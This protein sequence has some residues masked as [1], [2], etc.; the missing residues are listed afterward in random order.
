MSSRQN[1]FAW[2]SARI[3]KPFT[4]M[5]AA[6]QPPSSAAI[7]PR[8]TRNTATSPANGA[9]CDQP[10]APEELAQLIH[11]RPPML[12]VEVEVSAE[13]QVRD[14]R[15]RARGDLGLLERER[16]ELAEPAY[17]PE[18][19]DEERRHDRGS[20]REPL[21]PTARDDVGE[22][23]TR[24]HEEVRRLEGTGGADHQAGHDRIQD[25]AGREGADDEEHPRQDEHHRREVGHRGQA[26]RLWEELLAPTLLIAIDEER[27]RR[28]R[29]DHPQEGRPVRE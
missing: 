18:E 13:V 10:R 27:D 3:E 16:G 23:D 25:T 11:L 28:E 17:L 4:R 2:M 1:V 12:E 21:A 29:R 5:N 15:D 24:H 7:A 6:S 19:E 14:G 9:H 22:G 20:A 8:R 26:E